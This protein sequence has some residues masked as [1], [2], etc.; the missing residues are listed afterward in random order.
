MSSILA[1][2][3]P[4]VNYAAAVA[5]EIHQPSDG[6]EP[7]LRFQFK[8]GTDDNAFKTYNM[9]LPGMASPGDAPLSTFLSVMEP[10]AVNTTLEW[11]NVCAQKTARGCDALL[12]AGNSSSSSTTAVSSHHNRISPVGAGFLGA[13]LTFAVY[14]MLLGVLV[15]IGLLSFGRR[16]HRSG[17]ERGL[18]SEVRESFR[19]PRSNFFS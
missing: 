18:N 13:G 6:S 2:I 4:S 17:S 14:S 3:C 15:F 9:L 5:L 8:N 12:G 11:C 7:F 10:V 19:I 16:R 1:Y